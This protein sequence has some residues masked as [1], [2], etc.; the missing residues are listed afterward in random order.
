MKRC[1]MLKCVCAG[2]IVESTEMEYFPEPRNA[3]CHPK[4]D[5]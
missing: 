1:K 5:I 2:L 4:R 3:I